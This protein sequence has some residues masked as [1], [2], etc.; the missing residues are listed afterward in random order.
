M[1]P[2]S[3][4]RFA[5]P[6][7]W[8]PALLAAALLWPVAAPGAQLS[9]PDAAASP[10]PAAEARAQK[11][12]DIVRG[13]HPRQ[14]AIALPGGIATLNVP[15]AFCYLDANDSRQLLVDLWHNPP[16]AAE[17]V[18]GMLLPAQDGVP[19]VD[20]GVLITNE[21]E[22]YVKD[23]D[24]DSI[25]YGDL[26][27]KMQAATLANNAKRQQAGYP[28]MELVGWA[29][30]PRYDKA[31]K[32]LYWAKEL[33]IGDYPEH[34]LNYDVRILGRRGVLI[35]NAIAGMDQLQEIEQATPTILAM[36]NFN[37][38]H[39]Y[40]D[41]NPKTDKIAEI[42][43]AGL[44]AGGLLLKAGGLKALLVALL[45]AKKFIVIGLLAVG[46]FF[47]KLF[48]RRGVK[49]HETPSTS[50]LGDPKV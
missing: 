6:R 12:Q 22:G 14:G 36:V 29:A 31:T 1:T 33:K 49:T 30:P 2:R 17:G 27:K 5:F 23:G 15:A 8:F 47:Q 35:L 38:G 46:R 4:F 48:G 37:Q 10:D 19:N 21:N 42:G 34:T 11:M 18:L 32:K 26:L 40:A 50:T 3:P 24:A 45:A 9:T 20:W 13:F 43:L 39:R 16:S 7:P 28:A 44:V 25:N 41:F